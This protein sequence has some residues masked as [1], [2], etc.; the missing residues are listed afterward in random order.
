M[1]PSSVPSSSSSSSASIKVPSYP[2]TWRL[3]AQ[4]AEARVF[5]AENV[6]PGDEFSIVKERF[7]KKY[8]HKDLDTKLSRQRFNGE[9]RAMVKAAKSGVDVPR[10]DFVDKNSKRLVMEYVRGRTMKAFFD[11]SQ[12]LKARKLSFARAMG[13]AVA[14]LHN[15]GLVHGDL[16]TSNIMIRNENEETLTVIDFGLA[17]STKSPEDMGVDL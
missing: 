14:K 5:L 1:E 11:D 8:R 6:F 4:G 17:F 16:T 7:E 3:L 9:V 2:T 13:T 10:L 12:I 15:A